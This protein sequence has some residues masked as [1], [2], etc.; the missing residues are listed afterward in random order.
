MVSKYT[1]CAIWKE[2]IHWKARVIGVLQPK[3]GLSEGKIVVF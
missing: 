1:L 3:A 2:E